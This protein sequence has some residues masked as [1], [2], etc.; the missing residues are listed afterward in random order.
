MQN[1][2]NQ[3]DTKLRRI[4]CTRSIRDRLVSQVYIIIDKV[5][6]FDSSIR[7]LDKL[8][9]TCIFSPCE[10]QELRC[11]LDEAKG[12]FDTLLSINNSR[13]L[14]M[15]HMYSEEADRVREQL[16]TQ[17]TEEETM[18]LDLSNQMID[19]FHSTLVTKLRIS[20]NEQRQLVHQRKQT[21]NDLTK[22]VS[23]LQSDTVL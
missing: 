18:C 4:Q 6:T 19:V 13:Q 9:N 8:V 17:W 22:Y 1:E 21:L 12:L 2:L 14:Q 5:S 3:Q 15:A 7:L 11:T 16:I 23:T 20:A 10:C